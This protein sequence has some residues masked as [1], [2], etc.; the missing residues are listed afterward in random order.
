MHVKLTAEISSRLN[1]KGDRISA[2]VVSPPV[3][4][5]ATVEGQ[6]RDAKSSGSISKTSTLDLTFDALVLKDQG[7]IPIKSQIK[8]MINSKGQANV[9]DEGQIV[10]HKGNTGK[11]LMG[12]ALGAAI[13]A[14][15]GGAKGR[16]H[17][18][19]RGCRSVFNHGA[20]LRQRTVHH[21][22]TWERVHSRSESAPLAHSCGD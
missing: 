17:R 8:E 7:R 13:G 19:W 14:A 12:T 6:V 22:P 9:D 1:H 11:V 3:F 15:A 4:Q 20:R 10:Q 21:F 2:F 18:S 16:R 5:G